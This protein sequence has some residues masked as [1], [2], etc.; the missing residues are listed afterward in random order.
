[1]RWFLFRHIRVAGLNDEALREVDSLVEKVTLRILAGS[2]R[3]I[4]ED[5]SE[6]RL[7]AVTEFCESSQRTPGNKDGDVYDSYLLFVH[8]HR[9]MDRFKKAAL[10][11]KGKYSSKRAKAASRGHKMRGG[12]NNPK[13]V[14]QLDKLK[15]YCREEGVRPKVST[16]LGRFLDKR[17]QK[18]S[19][20]QL[21]KELLAIADRYPTEQ[22]KLFEELYTEFFEFV[23]EYDRLPRRSKP[24]EKQL[25]DWASRVRLKPHLL[26]DRYEEVNRVYERVVT[27]TGRRHKLAG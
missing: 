10:E 3:R 7:A 18:Q 12:L 26:G 2:N 9:P 8:P 23:E 16:R 1:M 6:R 4:S 24:E 22:E 25:A 15:A 19:D 11:L 20:P 13:V 5:E 27:T 21:V 17:H 14:E